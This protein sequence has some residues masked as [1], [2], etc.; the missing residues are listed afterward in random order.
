MDRLSLFKVLADASRYA[1]YDE[2]ARSASPLSTTEIAESLDLRPNTVRLHLEKMRDAGLLQMSPDRQG[3]VGRP[4][5]R[6]SVAPQAPAFGLEP[7][8]Y[9]LLAYLLAEVAARGSFDATS[10]AEVG[11]RHGGE[12]RRRPAEAFR[13]GPAGAEA[14]VEDGA[15]GMTRPRP[16]RGT[17]R[18]ACLRAVMDELADLGFDPELEGDGGAPEPGQPAAI[19]FTRCPFRDLAALYPDLVCQLHRGLT[20]GIVTCASLAEPGVTARLETFSSLVEAD[21][22]RIEVSIKS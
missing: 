17:V 15:G 18:D 21:P 12:G 22:C 9:R 1:I 11:R 20:Q 7:A 2:I 14:A 16:A 19:A 5:H 10:V 4:Q 13:A 3:A 6:W 8:G